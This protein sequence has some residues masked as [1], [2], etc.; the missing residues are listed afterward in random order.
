MWVCTYLVFSIYVDLMFAACVL[1]N[2][3][4]SG[5]LHYIRC[6]VKLVVLVG[7]VRRFS[8][9]TLEA[10]AV[11][12]I[13]VNLMLL[14]STICEASSKFL[15]TDPAQEE[16]FVLFVNRIVE[17]PVAFLG[18]VKLSRQ[19]ASQQVV[20]LPSLDT[21]RFVCRTCTWVELCDSRDGAGTEDPATCCICLESI[22]LDELV[23]QLTCKHCFH[24]DCAS[25][26]MSRCATRGRGGSMCPMRCA[27]T[28]ADGPSAV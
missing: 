13:F 21:S 6:G 16:L 20:P 23:T 24:V 7:L 12:T 19:S 3:E 9:R 17:T 26:W 1:W 22:E 18:A 25:Q 14:V 27:S 28:E 8:S 2:V 4:M 5:W 11:A 15:G 10:Y